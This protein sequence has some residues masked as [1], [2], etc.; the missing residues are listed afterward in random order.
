MVYVDM[1]CVNYWLQDIFTYFFYSSDMKWSFSCSAFMLCCNNYIAFCWAYAV[2]SNI[3]RFHMLF[4]I[5]LFV[6]KAG[7]HLTTLQ[8]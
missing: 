3:I 8:L 4:R 7:I 2:H 6:L 5:F 1:F